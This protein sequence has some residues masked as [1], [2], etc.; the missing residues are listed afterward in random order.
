MRAL[1]AGWCT[2]RDEGMSYCGLGDATQGEILYLDASK[3]SGLL[4]CSSIVV[5]W[6][7]LSS[8]NC[9]DDAASRH[10][11]RPTSEYCPHSSLPL[12]QERYGIARSPPIRR[13][14]ITLDR[15]SNSTLVRVARLPLSSPGQI[16][17][18]PTL[19]LY[20]NKR[21]EVGKSPRCHQVPS[22]F[23]PSP[24]SRALFNHGGCCICYE[25]PPHIM[26]ASC[27]V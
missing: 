17:G 8:C 5:A 10:N 25:R 27:S 19:P 24:G 7:Q 4:G 3:I 16:G 2:G 21:K 12:S 14:T 23:V 1:P 9:N 20:E 18:S 26:H 15:S 6:S 13:R 22:L 11:G